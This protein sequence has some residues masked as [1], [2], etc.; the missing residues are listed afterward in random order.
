M[1]DQGDVLVRIGG[2]EL[3]ALLIEVLFSFALVL[4]VLN[5]ATHEGTAGISHY[6]L[7]I[8]FTVLAGAMAGGRIS[9]GAFNPAVGHEDAG[10]GNAEARALL[11]ELILALDAPPG[12][13]LP[14]IREARLAGAKIVVRKLHTDGVQPRR[15]LAGTGMGQGHAEAGIVQ[16]AAQRNPVLQRPLFVSP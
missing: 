10:A 12:A 9:G 6:G 3:A 2:D 8:G 1:R 14:P 5:V 16:S 7:A 15:Q 13:P 11:R 4:V